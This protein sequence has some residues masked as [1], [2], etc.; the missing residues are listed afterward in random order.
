MS[1]SSVEQRPP[2]PD[3]E[4]SMNMEARQRRFEEN[5]RIVRLISEVAG[6]SLEI[7]QVENPH[8]VPNQP[9][10][11]VFNNHIGLD[12]DAPLT[13]VN[14]NPDK[15]LLSGR[16]D[17]AHSVLAGSLVIDYRGGERRSSGVAVKCFTKRTQEE[18]FERAM[19]E[20]AIMEDLEDCDELSLE[21]LAVAIAP[22]HSPFSGEVVLLTRR[23]DNLTSLDNLPWGRGVDNDRNVRSARLAFRVLGRFNAHLGYVHNDAKIKN[24]AAD[25]VTGEAGMIDYE[26]TTEFDRSDPA[27]AA[28]AT[29]SDFPMMLDSLRKR[30][31]VMPDG[32]REHRQM[33]AILCEDYL[34]AWNAAP[35]N[36]QERVVNEV[37]RVATE[38]GA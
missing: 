9:G 32:S 13:D 38:Y 5:L 11:Y 2:A 12:M 34:E 20:V 6:N 10:I 14:F 19:R 35:T 33:V 4:V 16:A 26:T 31:F 3:S 21:P 25:I 1:L 8:L 30:G 17:S 36:V 22:D 23:R 7:H 18:R 37:S 28:L 24:A 27:E 15:K 29:N